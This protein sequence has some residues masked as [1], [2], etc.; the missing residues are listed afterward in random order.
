MNVPSIL[1][2]TTFFGGSKLNPARLDAYTAAGNGV[3]NKIV[4]IANKLGID[5]NGLMRGSEWVKNNLPAIKGVVSAG[6]TLVNG[7]NLTAQIAAGTSL[8]KEGLPMLAGAIPANITSSIGNM[9][10]THADTIVKLGDVAQRVS[11]VDLNNLSAV[12]GMLGSLTGAG[13]AFEIKDKDSIIGVMSGLAVEGCKAG[14]PGAISAVLGSTPTRDILQ[15]CMSNVMPELVKLGN[16]GNLTEVG[17]FCKS[18]GFEL[19]GIG[20]Y[21]NFIKGFQTGSINPGN[22]PGMF[23][24]Y[25]D[26]AKNLDPNFGLVKAGNSI[27][28]SIKPITDLSPDAVQCLKTDYLS[29]LV[30]EEHVATLVNIPDLDIVPAPTGLAGSFAMAYD[31]MGGSELT[32]MSSKVIRL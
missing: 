3:Y 19:A 21:D 13:G 8:F 4:D 22:A 9:L 11:G 18:K 16:L 32:G 14:I 17:D 10:T 31:D 6:K 26:T 28:D 1:A 7:G 23:S 24:Q 29:G 30:P 20:G 2:A 27:Y 25:L 15:S 5:P 12:G